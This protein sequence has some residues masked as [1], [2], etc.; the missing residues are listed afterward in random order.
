[1]VNHPNRSRSK[2][3]A[4]VQTR[5]FYGP[6][7]ERSLIKGEDGRALVFSSRAQAQEWIDD[8]DQGIYHERNNEYGRPTYRI[9]AVDDL[10]EYLRWQL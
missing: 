8:A 9:R 4:I 1:M 6:R 5:H 10:P 3:V 7:D 2:P